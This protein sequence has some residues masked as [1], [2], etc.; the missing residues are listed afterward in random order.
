MLLYLFVIV[1]YI[2]YYILICVVCVV[3]SHSIMWCYNILC[4]F[5]SFCGE[6]HYIVLCLCCMLRYV[7]LF[8][9]D[10][11]RLMFLMLFYKTF[12]LFY[13]F[14]LS[15]DVILCISMYCFVFF[16]LIF[17]YCYLVV[18]SVLFCNGIYYNAIY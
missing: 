3:L 16:H 8:C 7:A 12:M 11:R 13:V 10:L 6:L 14:W 15:N 1:Q 17:C 9:I 4:C 18:E 2:F 5:I